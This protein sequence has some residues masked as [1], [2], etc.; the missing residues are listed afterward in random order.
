MFL[1]S[2]RYI[3]GSN[4]QGIKVFWFDKKYDQSEKVD[5]E[6]IKKSADDILRT[7]EQADMF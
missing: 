4:P 2:L 6:A 1:L 7:F 5:L 3:E